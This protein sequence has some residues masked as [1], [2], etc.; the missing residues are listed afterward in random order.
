MI[1]QRRSG[2][3]YVIILTTQVTS[4]RSALV[5]KFNGESATLEM[6]AATGEH[7]LSA[8]VPQLSEFQSLFYTPNN[9]SHYQSDATE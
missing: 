4:Q 9:T 6:A 7:G 1:K 2:A 5:T 3:C 8:R